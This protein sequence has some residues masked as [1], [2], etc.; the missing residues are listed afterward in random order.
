MKLVMLQLYIKEG[1]K[2]T[3]VDSKNILEDLKIFIKII[4]IMV[5]ESTLSICRDSLR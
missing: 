1:Y 3:R 5:K 2:V 4:Y